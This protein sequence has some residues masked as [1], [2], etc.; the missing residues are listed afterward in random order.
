M[1]SGATLDSMTDQKF[2]KIKLTIDIDG[3]L[4]NAA[5]IKAAEEGTSLEQVIEKLLFAYVHEARPDM[6]K[7]S[8]T[9]SITD[10]AKFLM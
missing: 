10:T 1:G 4:L 9:T 5:Q 2:S 7:S 6:V 3:P 8:K